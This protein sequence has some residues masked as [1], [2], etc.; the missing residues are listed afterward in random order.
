MVKSVDL[1]I[2]GGIALTGFILMTAKKDGDG[3]KPKVS[4]TIA[5]F[6]VT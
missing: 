5:S 6:E 4:A 3:I 1:L 2:L